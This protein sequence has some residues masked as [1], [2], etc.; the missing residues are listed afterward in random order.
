MVAMRSFDLRLSYLGKEKS[1]TILFE[2]TIDAR[3][4]MQ[5]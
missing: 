3:N 4:G 2:T 5:E 1:R